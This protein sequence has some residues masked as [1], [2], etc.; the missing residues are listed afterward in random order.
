MLYDIPEF[1]LLRDERRVG[2]ASRGQHFLRFVPFFVDAARSSTS[3]SSSLGSSCAE[4]A[5]DDSAENV[6]GSP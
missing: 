5:S 3:D 2:C 6:L 4:V 1:K